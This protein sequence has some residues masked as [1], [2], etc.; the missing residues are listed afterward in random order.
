MPKTKARTAKQST[1]AKPR[2]LGEDDHFGEQ[3][4]ARG[5]KA[6][7]TAIE[8]AAKEQDLKNAKKATAK[9]NR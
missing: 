1:D 4:F 5:L 2:P 3:T 8:E 7:T 6:V 9:K